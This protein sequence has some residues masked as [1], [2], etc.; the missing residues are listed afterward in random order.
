MLT[1]TK[2]YTPKEA[3]AGD[4]AWT[5]PVKLGRGRM[6][7]GGD[8][9][10]RSLAAQG[11]RIK[12]YDAPTSTSTAPVEASEVVKTKATAGKVIEE[13]TILYDKNAYKAV[14]EDGKVYGM[15]E[16]CNTCRVSLVQNHCLNPTIL[17]GI[18]VKIVPR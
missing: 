9:H 15:P 8:A 14:G 17:G 1:K 4:P 18:P 13:F 10:C 12:G 6:P 3:L 7:A 11:Y 5:T 2:T 16:V